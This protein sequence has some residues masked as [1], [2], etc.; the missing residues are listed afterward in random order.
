MAKV[1][2]EKWLP[3]VGYE[4]LYEV[5]NIGNVRSLFRYKK[6]L[7]PTKTT[8]GYY[9]V[10][11]FKNKIGTNHYLHRLVAMAFI[12]HEDDK[13]FV[14][15]KDE[16]KTN[17]NTENLEW[18]SHVENCNWG[19]AIARR[20]ANTNYANRRINNANQIKTCSK[21]I[22]QFT[23]GGEFIREWSSASE[24][25][26]ELGLSSVSGIRKCVLGERK[27]AFGYVFKRKVE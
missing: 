2:E 27:T 10:Q 8:N 9:Y 19:T 11:L 24:C 15:H 26:R 13:P 17:N 1:L 7:K 22:L 6:V 25:A 14:N 16:V 12:P 21:P 23:R 3:V 5:S 18:V 20:L 4:G